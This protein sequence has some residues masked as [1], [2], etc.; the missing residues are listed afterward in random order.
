MANLL[1]IKK[2]AN[3]YFTFVLNGDLANA[4]KNKRNDLTMVGDFAHIKSSEGANF[5]KQ[6]NIIYS[7]I[8]IV[9]GVTSL[10]PTSPDD[11][12]TKLLSVGYFD[13]ISGSGGGGV[14]RFDDLQDTFEYFGKDGQIPIVDEAQLRLIPFVLPDASYL[15]KFPT[16]LVPNKILKVDPTGTNYILVDPPAGANGYVQAF[17]YSGG[18]QE[19]T[20][21]TTANLISVVIN[22]GL[23]DPVDWNQVGN[24]LTILNYTLVVNDRIIATGVI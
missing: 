22:G 14:D 10:V 7:N 18:A 3:D 21:A 9:D 20:L 8:T 19:F 15:S 5:I 11:L 24:V 17:T 1:T 2:E 16:P 4:I 23:A 6:Q 13:W 12:F